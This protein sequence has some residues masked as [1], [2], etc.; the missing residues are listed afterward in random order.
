MASTVRCTPLRQVHRLYLDIRLKMRLSIHSGQTDPTEFN[1]PRSALFY[2]TAGSGLW[3]AEQ[4]RSLWI[5]A[6]CFCSAML[7][8]A[9]TESP[10]NPLPPSA[11]DL[12]LLT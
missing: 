4:P 2:P 5:G 11:S 9:C 1:K 8:A 7:L 6:V 3:N 12:T 10:R